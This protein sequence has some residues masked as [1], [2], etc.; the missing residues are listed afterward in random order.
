MAKKIYH[1]RVDGETRE[2]LQN[3]AGNIQQDIKNFVGKEKKVPLGNVIRYAVLPKY[4]ENFIQLDLK[5]ISKEL[6]RIKL[7]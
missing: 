3:L 5:S 1:I 6:R 2:R 7:K 4:N